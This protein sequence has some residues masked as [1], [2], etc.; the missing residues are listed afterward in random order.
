MKR[1][2]EK[3]LFCKQTG[4]SDD[5][6]TIQKLV[7]SKSSGTYYTVVAG[8]T[9]SRIATKYSTTVNNLVQ[10]NGISNPNKIYPGQ[11]LRVR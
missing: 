10:M 3:K 4:Y 2:R 11:K 9:L 5:Y 8:D 1:L 6:D 7:N